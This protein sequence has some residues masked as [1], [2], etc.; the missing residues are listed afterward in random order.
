MMNGGN[1]ILF[2]RGIQISNI[3]GNISK[4]EYNAMYDGNKGKMILNDNG[5][6]YYIEADDNDGYEW[7]LQVF[8]G[9]A[10]FLQHSLQNNVDVDKFAKLATK[11]F[12][13][14]SFI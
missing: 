5:S 9:I 12:R 14:D 2:S 10:H 1:Q 11:F 7:S 6:K 8:R 13:H 4:K 3:N